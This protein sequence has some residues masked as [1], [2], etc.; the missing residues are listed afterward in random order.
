[1]LNNIVIQADTD[2]LI[3]CKPDQS[4]W[5]EDEQK[6]FL[7]KL[8]ASLPPLIRFEHDGYFNKIIIVKSKNYILYDGKKIKTKGSSIRDQKKEPALREM[9]DK[10][11]DAMLFD[12]TDTLV[13][14]YHSYIHEALNVKDIKRWSM[15]KTI[16]ESILKCKGWTEED[17]LSKRLRKN[18]TDVWDAI[19]HLDDLQAGG[20]VYCYPTVLSSSVETKE[21]KNGNTKEK[22]TQITGLKTID[23]WTGDENKD[24]LLERVYDTISIFASVIDLSQFIDYTKKKN[25]PLLEGLR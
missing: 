18:E 4:L 21:Y 7:V 8:N 2:S 9:M 23:L 22:V 16:T 5:S 11:I 19:K 14:I 10:F 15:K 6:E 25:K 12:R 1:M 24:K 20:K 13:D 17:I 3:I